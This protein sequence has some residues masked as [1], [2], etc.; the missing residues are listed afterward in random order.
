MNKMVTT[1]SCDVCHEVK[2]LK[3][4]E[5]GFIKFVC[6]KCNE[7]KITVKPKEYRGLKKHCN[8]LD[9]S[10]KISK[11]DNLD[12][13]TIKKIKCGK[14]N[15]EI[16]W[17][18]I[19]DKGNEI[20]EEEREHLLNTVKCE[21]CESRFFVIDSTYK[22]PKVKCLECGSDIRDIKCDDYVSLKEVCSCKNNIFELL[23]SEKIPTCRE[24]GNKAEKLYVDND[25]N[26]IDRVTREL[27]IIQDNYDYLERQIDEMKTEFEDR[28]YYVESD[29]SRLRGKISDQEEHNYILQNDI[30][31]IEREI[32]SIGRDINSM[33]YDINRLK[34][35]VEEMDFKIRY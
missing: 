16:E 22:T 8:C 28:I 13:I 30:D 32:S 17:I 34:E 33:E 29:I 5:K 19:D 3:E 35:N 11:I 20:T 7:V 12:K 15:Q 31:S 9:G 21:Q 27:L 25:G 2:F 1:F 4:E 23:K 6:Q 10:F 18:A 24:C 14:C 26:E